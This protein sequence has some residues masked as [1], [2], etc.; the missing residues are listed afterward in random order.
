MKK[1]MLAMMCGGALIGCEDAAK[2]IDDAQQAANEAVDSV[3]QK[4]EAIDLE[5]FNLDELNL[6]Q[7]GDAA[8]KAK[9]LVSSVQEALESDLANPQV[10][11]EAKE[12]IA[13]A[14]RCLVDA[15]SV[16][17]AEKIIN[18]VTASIS[19]ENALSLIEKSVEKAEAAKE[20]VM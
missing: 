17:T 12:H 9:E 14:Y 1:L 11:T 6:G 4:M 10:V 8:D 2:A 15:S 19:D 13:N 3:Q 20:C 16:S 18:E 5:Q 7:F